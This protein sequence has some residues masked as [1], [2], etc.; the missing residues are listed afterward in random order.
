MYLVCAAVALVD[1][2]LRHEVEQ[3]ASFRVAVEADV[4]THAVARLALPV[5][6]DL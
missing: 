1:E 6:V 3:I 2:C 5:T 4:V